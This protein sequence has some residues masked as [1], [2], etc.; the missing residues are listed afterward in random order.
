MAMSRRRP[1]PGLEDVLERPDFNR[2]A[3]LVGGKD[4]VSAIP[5]HVDRSHW[6]LGEF[7][8]QRRRADGCGDAPERPLILAKEIDEA[9]VRTPV[10][11][12]PYPRDHVVRFLRS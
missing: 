8:H 11:A 3:P 9:A 2:V 12:T 1:P 6:L 7:A 10:H 4:D 5:R